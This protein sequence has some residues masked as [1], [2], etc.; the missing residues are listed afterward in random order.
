MLP[1][2]L[3]TGEA[4][5]VQLLLRRRNFAQRAV[6]K[7]RGLPGGSDVGDLLS[8]CKRNNSIAKA[9]ETYYHLPIW[10]KHL[11]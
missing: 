2:I 4:I 5:D 11:S 6:G 8:A 7:A 9:R 3:A 1:T 10:N